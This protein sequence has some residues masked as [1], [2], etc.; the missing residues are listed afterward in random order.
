VVLETLESLS[1]AP[2]MLLSP[3]GGGEYYMRRP[4]SV[5]LEGLSEY[6]GGLRS[7]LHVTAKVAARADSALTE[8]K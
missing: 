4:V 1:R 8:V 2:F 6:A 7:R 3:L 5:A